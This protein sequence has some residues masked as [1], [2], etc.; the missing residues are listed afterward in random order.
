MSKI[1]DIIALCIRVIVYFVSGVG[2]SVI[3]YAYFRFLSA[4]CPDMLIGISIILIS[5]FP[6]Y[7]AFGKQKRRK[8]YKRNNR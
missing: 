6:I 1:L 3:T 7:W 2:V 4:N 8:S 5:S